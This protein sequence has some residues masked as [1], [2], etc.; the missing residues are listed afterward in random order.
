MNKKPDARCAD[1]STPKSGACLSRRDI[2]KV[3]GLAGTLCYLQGL[4][5]FWGQAAEA[6]QPRRVK[7]AELSPQSAEWLK[8]FGPINRLALP[9][10]PFTG[11]QP[12][13]AHML[14]TIDA[15]LEGQSLPEPES[16][17]V[18]VVG[19]G[20]SGLATAY[21]LSKRGIKP[22]V[23]E[24]AERFGGNSKGESWSGIDYSIGA[25][26]FVPPDPGSP[27]DRFYKDLQVGPRRFYRVV[28]QSE[29]PVMLRGRL[30]HGFWDGR[31][32]D[33]RRAQQFRK[34]E[35]YL[36]QV[37]DG[38]GEIYPEIPTD[39]PAMMKRLKALDGVSFREQLER[40]VG[41]LIPHIE[42]ALEHYCW[43]SFGG[44]M[45]ELS[46]AAGLNFLA[47]EID[48]IHA[49]P[50]GNAAIAERILSKLADSLP[51]QHLR[52]GCMVLKVK[53]TDDGTVLIVYQDER[54]ALRTIRARRVVMSCPKFI[55]ARILDGIEDDRRAAIQQLRYR[56][57]LVCNVL[58]DRPFD[59]RKVRE[60]FDCFLLANGEL[61]P[62]TVM[63][64]ALD[65]KAT[66]VILANFARPSARQT[67][68]TFYRA[69]PF[70][71]ARPLLLDEGAHDRF[72]RE[73][74][75][76]VADLL[77]PLGFG[78]ADVKDYRLARWGHP[79]PL[80]AAGLLAGGVVESLRRPMQDKVFFVE[81]DNWA[82]PAIETALGEALAFAPQ[83][84]A[85]LGAR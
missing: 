68:L 63:E 49:A 75:A 2:I 38:D 41:S 16:A 34:L 20:M 39:D 25:A 11:D 47:G 80:A 71:G 82:V 28:K 55:A 72:A 37:A 36:K 31:G 5:S 85:G 77:P 50:G 4:G 74:K 12:A 22:V 9:P 14:W 45:S 13:R 73:F 23:L 6:V 40:K 64:Q 26:Y 69:F 61:P 67:V 8:T 70:D 65:H 51:L 62:G 3:A 60:F 58:I 66:D 57:Y 10:D 54:Q 84:A 21:L 33:R 43:S 52:A 59:R 1:Q 19:G 7:S 44:S 56:G 24:Q 78:D 18:V 76:Q 30:V 79:L 35:R 42:T 83:I 81:Q 53:V 46:A 29:E 27:L 32:A 15:V 48:T 17:D